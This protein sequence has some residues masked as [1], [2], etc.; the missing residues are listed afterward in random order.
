M[1]QIDRIKESSYH[2]IAM[3]KNKP[4]DGSEGA[5]GTGIAI[6]KNLIA[7]NLYFLITNLF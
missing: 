5:S 1:W 3:W 7:T 6:A 2:V 4:K